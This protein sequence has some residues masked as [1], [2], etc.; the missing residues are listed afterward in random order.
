MKTRIKLCFCLVACFIVSGAMAQ[1][2]EFKVIGYYAGRTIP[3][4]SFQ[5]EQLTHLIW[6]FGHLKGNRL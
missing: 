4:D 1:R 6:C 5:V 3:P 2:N